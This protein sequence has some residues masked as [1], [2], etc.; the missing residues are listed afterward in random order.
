MSCFSILLTFE[1]ELETVLGAKFLEGTLVAEGSK[2]SGKVFE[3]E[4]EGTL[5][6]LVVLEVTGALF[7]REFLITS[8][9]IDTLDTEEIEEGGKVVEE[10]E[11]GMVALLEVLEDD[12]A[13]F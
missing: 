3:E 9:V 13:L 11:E 12:G 7:S 4:K 6:L 5:I 1:I 2:E 10:E 8:A